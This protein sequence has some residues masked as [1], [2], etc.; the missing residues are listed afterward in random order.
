VINTILAVS[1]KPSRFRI[2]Y[3][4]VLNFLLTGAVVKS[5][6]L[7]QQAGSVFI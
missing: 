2:R 6:E 7:Q 5:A 1:G 3:D 4:V